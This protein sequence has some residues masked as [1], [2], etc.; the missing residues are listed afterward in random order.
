MLSGPRS[1]SF[2]DVPVPDHLED[3]QALGRI[4]A[5]GICGTDWE[6][7]VGQLDETGILEYPCI[8]GHEPLLRVERLTP[9]IRE[10][11]ILPEH[12]E[13]KQPL[14]S[15]QSR[16]ENKPAFEAIVNGTWTLL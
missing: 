4:E 15:D 7:Y 16:W 12:D 11:I 13:K 3:G 1:M 5:S 9:T 14:T 2:Q 6:Q 8:V 10:D